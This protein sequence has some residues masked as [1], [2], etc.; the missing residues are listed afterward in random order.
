MDA[1]GSNQ[2]RLTNDPA[3]D[4]WPSWGPSALETF[5][6]QP[7]GTQNDEATIFRTS[8]GNAN[9]DESPQCSVT[10]DGFG[11]DR[12][13]VSNAQYSLC[14]AEGNCGRAFYA[15]D[16]NFNGADY[17]V[18]SVSWEDATDYFSWVGAWLPTE[19]EWG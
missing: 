17:L 18:A 13:E 16:T 10:L 1:D 5:S 7:T 12:A 3:G 8:D 2:R 4:Y 15:V 9:D 14:V 6:Q 19:V 11:I